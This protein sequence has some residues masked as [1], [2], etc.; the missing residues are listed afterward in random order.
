MGESSGSQAF[1]GLSSGAVCELGQLI[2][3]VGS[4]VGQ[5]LVV[6]NCELFSLILIPEQVSKS[7]CSLEVKRANLSLRNTVEI[8]EFTP[9]EKYDKAAVAD[10]S[11][12]S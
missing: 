11:L 12:Y 9:T 6:G 4:K 8:S 2:P 1:S 7:Q 3:G 10:Q 5:S